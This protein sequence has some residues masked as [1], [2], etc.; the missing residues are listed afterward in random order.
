MWRNLVSLLWDG[1]QT[2]GEALT[3]QIPPLR[4]RLNRVLR[5]E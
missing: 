2:C 4:T 1:T 3:D 5:S